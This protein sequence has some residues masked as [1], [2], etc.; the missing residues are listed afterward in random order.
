MYRQMYLQEK[1]EIV[2]DAKL[3]CSGDMYSSDFCV[4]II[5]SP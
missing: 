5:Y 1:A 2:S 4:G 3:F